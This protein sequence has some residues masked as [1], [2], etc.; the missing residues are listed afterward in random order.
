VK[1]GKYQTCRSTISRQPFYQNRKCSFS[2]FKQ[3]TEQTCTS[4]IGVGIKSKISNFM[5]WSEHSRGTTSIANQLQRER[6]IVEVIL[7]NYKWALQLT[8]SKNTYLLYL[9]HEVFEKFLHLFLKCCFIV[10]KLQD[11]RILTNQN[12]SKMFLILSTNKENL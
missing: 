6:K 4:N 1:R 12:L 3:P 2:L 10:S 11:M 9:F 8:N 5:G 7:T